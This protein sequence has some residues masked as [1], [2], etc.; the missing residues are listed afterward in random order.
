MHQPA[1]VYRNPLSHAGNQVQV[2]T[3]LDSSLKDIVTLL[4]SAKSLP[5]SQLS[6]AHR[7]SIRHVYWEPDTEVWTT[8][9]I[10]Q[11]SHK[12]IVKSSSEARGPAL[13]IL[14]DF[15]W[16]SLC[17]PGL[18]YFFL[19]HRLICLLQIYRRRLPRHCVHW[20]PI[21]R[22]TEW[23]SQWFNGK[24]DFGCRSQG[25]RRRLRMEWAKRRA[26]YGSGAIEVR[27][28]IALKRRLRDHQER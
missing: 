26:R 5:P 22:C 17:D 19:G 1:G 2:Y 28:V 11:L 10:A 21:S 20:T 12:D 6:P 16:V 13:K 27:V 24:T 14:D 9:D 15:G 4:L 7:V 25:S 8:K 18:P 3:W 23:S